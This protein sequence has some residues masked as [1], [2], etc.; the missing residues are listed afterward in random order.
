MQNDDI[1]VGDKL[2]LIDY[3]GRPVAKGKVIAI[4][5]EYHQRREDYYKYFTM[6]WL[7]EDIVIDD[8]SAD[9][10]WIKL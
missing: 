1:K 2:C 5:V 4:K 9:L 7:D 3:R 6:E 10:P 8:V